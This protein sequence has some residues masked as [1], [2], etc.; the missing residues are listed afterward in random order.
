MQ[1]RSTRKQK[2]SNNENDHLQSNSD[3]NESD[4]NIKLISKEICEK[5][6]ASAMKKLNQLE[7]PSKDEHNEA[8]DQI[9]ELQN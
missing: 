9:S 1:T 3:N 2:D 8:S 4:E 6:A 5:I 7:L